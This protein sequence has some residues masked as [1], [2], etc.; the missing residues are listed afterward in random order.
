MIPPKPNEDMKMCNQSSQNKRLVQS[1]LVSCNYM[2]MSLGTYVPVLLA[3]V[4]N[5]YLFNNF[6]FVLL[7]PI[8]KEFFNSSP[9]LPRKDAVKRPRINASIAI[10]RH[11]VS[12]GW[13]PRKVQL[14]AAQ[15]RLNLFFVK[16]NEIFMLVLFLLI[17]VRLK[18]TLFENKQLNK[19]ARRSVMVFERT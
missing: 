5:S 15:N 6:D 1:D 14:C 8:L 16:K 12:R 18:W 13:D 11:V 2:K 7:W 10:V 17:V 3:G 4:N 19:Q 9:F